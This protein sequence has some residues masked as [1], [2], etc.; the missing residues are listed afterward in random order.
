MLSRFSISPARRNRLILVVLLLL[1]VCWMLYVAKSV[2]LPYIISLVV[3][4]LEKI[5]A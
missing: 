2:L 4:Y 3:A 5:S 1:L